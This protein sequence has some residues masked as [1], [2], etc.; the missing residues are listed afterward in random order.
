MRSH[1]RTLCGADPGTNV[2]WNPSGPLSP[3]IRCWRSTSAPS[4][5]WSWRWGCLP[6]DWSAAQELSAR[7]PRLG[8]KV[9][10]LH[11][12]WPRSG[13]SFTAWGRRSRQPVITRWAL[14]LGGSFICERPS[15]GGFRGRGGLGCGAR[16]GTSSAAN[17]S[18]VQQGK[19]ISG[20]IFRAYAGMG[21]HVRIDLVLVVDDPPRHFPA[22]VGRAVMR[23]CCRISS[24]SR[25]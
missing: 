1:E 21:F 8:S 13:P 10:M 9:D 24:R 3:A 12:F 19:N 11:C 6:F 17:W 2:P 4:L 15:L 7:A 20:G 14:S 23:L 18:S 22:P 25:I 16:A 5:T